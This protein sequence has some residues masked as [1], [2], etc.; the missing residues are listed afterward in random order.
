MSKQQEYYWRTPYG[1]FSE[2][3]GTPAFEWC[4]KEY[5]APLASRPHRCRDAGDGFCKCGA[6]VRP[7]E[8]PHVE[9]DLLVEHLAPDVVEF[10]TRGPD[11]DCVL[12]AYWLAEPEARALIQHEREAGR[13]ARVLGNADGTSP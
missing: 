8:R 2:L 9:R 11:A 1:D 12:H 5:G 6:D 10:A 3:P 13:P 4:L 7:P